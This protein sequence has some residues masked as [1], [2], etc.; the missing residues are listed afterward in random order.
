[1]QLQEG[2]KEPARERQPVEPWVEP[3]QGLA[4][5]GLAEQGLGMAHRLRALRLP[6]SRLP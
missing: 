5:Q 3:L 4:V 2:E 6:R 1:M